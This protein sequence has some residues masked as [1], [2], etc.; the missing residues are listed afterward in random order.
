MPN[1]PIQIGVL[2]GIPD[3]AKYITYRINSEVNLEHCLRQLAVQ[4]DGDTAVMGIGSALAAKLGKSIPGLVTM[5]NYRHGDL[6]LATDQADLFIW[7]RATGGGETMG[8]LANRSMVLANILADNFE[9]QSHWDAFNYSG[10]DLSG[11]ED[12]TENPEGDEA[13]AAGFINEGEPGI[14]G[15]SFVTLQPWQHRLAPFKQQ[16]QQDQ[17]DTIGRRLSDNLEYS[18]APASAHVKRSAQESFDPEAF[19]LRRS[20]PWVRG[21]QNGL[22][23]VAFAKDFNAFDVIMKRMIGCDDDII[24]GLFSFSQPVGGGFYWCPPVI[25][26]QVD[27]QALL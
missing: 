18:E 3:F 24:D 25:D 9:E 23:F 10:R 20:M 27:L 1:L 4:I 6:A 11:Y 16:S 2:A 12:G 22:I 8:E 21:S 26:G 19:M 14:A 13:M 5:P 17:D 15:S 7:L